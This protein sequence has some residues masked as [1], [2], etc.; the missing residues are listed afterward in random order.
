M[1]PVGVRK[2]VKSPYFSV[3]GKSLDKVWKMLDEIEM[4]PFQLTD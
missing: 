2:T 3:I 4:G 1:I